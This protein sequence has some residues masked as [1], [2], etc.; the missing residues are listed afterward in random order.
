MHLVVDK[1]NCDIVKCK[2][3]CVQVCPQNKKDLD[4]IKLFE[5]K[6]VIDN[7]TCI[8]CL[9]CVTACPL[10][11]IIV[12]DKKK[13]KKSNTRIKEHKTRKNEKVQA[14]KDLEERKP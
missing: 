4:T 13:K 9:R 3:E 11:A 10:E 2:Q 8:G 7:S 5:N 12:K 1:E 14:T 6:A